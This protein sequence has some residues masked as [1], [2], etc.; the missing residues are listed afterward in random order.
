MKR[1]HAEFSRLKGGTPPLTLEQVARSRAAYSM[2]LDDLNTA[3]LA[4]YRLRFQARIGV[5]LPAV[6]EGKNGADP[7]VMLPLI[8]GLPL[9][10]SPAW[11]EQALLPKDRQ[12]SAKRHP[13]RA[14]L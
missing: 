12:S 14:R 8:A 2:M 5:P 3:W 10:P 7:A 1:H 9:R 13:G 11:A 4:D 6:P